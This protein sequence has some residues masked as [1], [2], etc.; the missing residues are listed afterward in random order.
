MPELSGTTCQEELLPVPAV[1][2]SNQ[3]TTAE[4]PPSY[5]QLQDVAANDTTMHHTP[6]KAKNSSGVPF[7]ASLD[8]SRSTSAEKRDSV[9]THS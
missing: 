6:Q 3:A 4:V 9:Q 2:V 7:E 1:T 5:R 8:S